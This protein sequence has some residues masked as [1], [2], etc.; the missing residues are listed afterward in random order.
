MTGHVGLDF[1]VTET[2]RRLI[3]ATLTATGS[4]V[5]PAMRKYDAWAVKTD[6]EVW[7]VETYELFAV[8]KKLKGVF[9]DPV[10]GYTAPQEWSVRR[11][12]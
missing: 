10:G 5:G 3:Q 4:S 9:V 1:P 6:P 7:Q 2:G 8:S 12:G 11:G